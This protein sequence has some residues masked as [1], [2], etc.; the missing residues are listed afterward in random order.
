MRNKNHIVKSYDEDLNN[1]QENIIKMIKLAEKQL[2]NLYFAIS[3][4]KHDL[5]NTII[6]QDDPINELDKHIINS[7]IDILSLRNPVAYDLRFV[8]TSSHISKNIER[9]GDNVVN[10]A[11]AFLSLNTHSGEIDSKIL[12]MLHILIEMT[13]NTEI[14]LVNKD[15]QTIKETALKDK[16]IDNY[17]NQT[18]SLALNKIQSNS[19]SINDLH[20]YLLVARSL[21]RVGDHLVNICKQ[22]CFIETSKTDVLNT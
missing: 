16:T 21:E 13:L 12:E 11:D 19:Q 8:F 3:E 17:H 5:L 1:L 4:K 7:S 10:I 18:I 2:S 9:I 20:H 22:I 14:N 6:N 15:I